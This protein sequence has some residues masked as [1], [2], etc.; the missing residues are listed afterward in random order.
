MYS[1]SSTSNQ[2]NGTTMLNFRPKIIVYV[3]CIKKFRIFG[4]VYLSIYTI[5]E[6]LWKRSA[7]HIVGRHRRRRHCRRRNDQHNSVH[8]G[9][10]VGGARPHL[11]RTTGAVS[12]LLCSLAAVASSSLVSNLLWFLRLPLVLPRRVV[13]SYFLLC[14]CRGVLAAGCGVRGDCGNQYCAFAAMGEPRLAGGPLRVHLVRRIALA[15][16]AS[17]LLSATKY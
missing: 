12:R 1:Y 9:A 4:I 7:H 3:S 5:Q 16:L 11:S 17:G 6:A 2:N 15:S 8:G 13:Y 10:R 14:D